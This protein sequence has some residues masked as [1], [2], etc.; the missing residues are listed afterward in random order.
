[1][2]N[3]AALRDEMTAAGAWVIGTALCARR[4]ARRGVRS[5]G[6]RVAL[7]VIGVPLV[8]ITAH[9]GGLM[10]HGRDFLDW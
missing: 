9:A 5:G 1:M 3:L 7:V 6:V 10:T 8:A 4:D 2:R